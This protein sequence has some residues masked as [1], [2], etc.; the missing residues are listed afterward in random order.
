MMTYNS[1]VL[2]A[3]SYG[4]HNN[5]NAPGVM[6][7]GSGSKRSASFAHEQIIYDERSSKPCIKTSHRCLFTLTKCVQ[8]PFLKEVSRLPFFVGRRRRKA[9]YKRLCKF[10][11]K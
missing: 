10:T 6:T 4:C 3:S 7:T 11:N 9:T 8:V 5:H 2:V 1:A